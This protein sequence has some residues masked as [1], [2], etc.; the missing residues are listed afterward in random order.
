VFRDLPP[1]RRSRATGTRAQTGRPVPYEPSRY[2]ASARLATLRRT[3][4][5]GRVDHL[6]RRSEPEDETAEEVL[7][8]DLDRR[9]N[10][11]VGQAGRRRRDQ[12]ID[13]H[14]GGLIESDVGGARPRPPTKARAPPSAAGSDRAVTARRDANPGDA[15]DLASAASPRRDRRRR[16]G[17]TSLAGDDGVGLD[18][19]LVSSPR[20]APR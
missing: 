20:F 11:A 1:R 9:D 17:R 15:R 6:G 8:G 4:E 16:R 12:P 13:E 7:V 14:V 10:T 3:R 2:R 19:P 5:L 18:A